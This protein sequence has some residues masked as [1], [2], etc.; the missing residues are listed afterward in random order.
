MDSQEIAAGWWPG[1]TRC[2][3]A[4][5]YAYAHPAPSGFELDSLAPPAA[6]WVANLGEFALDWEH[7]VASANPLRD[8]ARV[9]I[10]GSQARLYGVQLGCDAG[11]QR[12]GSHAT[13][14]LVTRELRRVHQLRLV[15]PAFAPGRI[16]STY[17]LATSA[18]RQ[19]ESSLQRAK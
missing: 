14:C 12:G 1:D 8:R 6:R 4:A 16:P 5:F 19:S 7:V 10:L 17:D 2:P 15:R 13:C 11:S 18:H 9:R 3:R